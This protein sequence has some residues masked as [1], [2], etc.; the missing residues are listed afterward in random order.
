M[1]FRVVG[2]DPATVRAIAY[3]VRD[4]MRGDEGVD[5][6]HLNWNEQTPRVRL[7]IDQDR[8]RLLGLTPQDVSNRLRLAI[9]GV[10]IT[11]LRDGID[12]VDVVARAIPQE[13][14][15]LSDGSATW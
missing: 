9:S 15:D 13:R 14:G 8:A 1:Q 11:T 6:P 3:Q 2:S 5:D 7:V 10:T 12:Q 4:V